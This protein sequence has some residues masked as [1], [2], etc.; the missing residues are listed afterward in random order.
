M[1][2]HGVHSAPVEATVE[3]TKQCSRLEAALRM[4][5]TLSKCRRKCHPHPTGRVVYLEWVLALTR[6]RRSRGA[7]GSY[8]RRAPDSL[9]GHPPP[10][11]LNDANQRIPQHNFL[12]PP[13]PMQGMHPPGLQSGSGL[14]GFMA[15]TVQVVAQL[16]QVVASDHLRRDTQQGYRQLKPKRDVSQ[17]TASTS[18][19]LIDE[20]LDFE[21]DIAELGLPIA[22]VAAFAHLRAVVKGPAKDVLEY[23]LALGP[24]IRNISVA[25]AATSR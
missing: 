8:G 1:P 4:A 23:E 13:M 20:F 21:T 11:V 10:Y 17:I 6:R 2:E 22:S 15:Q 16:A 24:Q 25:T 9:I 19:V 7:T 18:E 12:P 14:E 5:P 3:G